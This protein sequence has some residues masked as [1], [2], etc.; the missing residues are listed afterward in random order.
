MISRLRFF[1]DGSNENR[2]LSHKIQTVAVALSVH[3]NPCCDVIKKMVADNAQY[4]SI[5]SGIA[6]HRSRYNFRQTGHRR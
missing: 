4:F 6:I 1:Q 3:Q 5:S 2:K